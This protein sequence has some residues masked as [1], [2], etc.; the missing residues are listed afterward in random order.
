MDVRI[1]GAN[2]KR[3]LQFLQFP[4]KTFHLPGRKKAVV[5][6]PPECH[7]RANSDARLIGIA[8]DGVDGAAHPLTE[9][10]DRPRIDMD[11]P[12]FAPGRPK[13]LAVGTCQLKEVA[14]AVLSDD[15][16]NSGLA[17]QHTCLPPAR[18]KP[19]SQFGRI[20]LWSILP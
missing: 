3:P 5:Q 15:V 7:E 16:E 8:I 20:V 19:R 6:S 1:V 4:A 10:A 9:N 18:A 12:H 17:G 13:W 11:L 14:V 2:Q